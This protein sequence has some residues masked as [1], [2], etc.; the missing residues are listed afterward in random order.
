MRQRESSLGVAWGARRKPGL[1]SPANMS[2][3]G[4]SARHSVPN[5]TLSLVN[6]RL[7][8]GNVA[9][10]NRGRPGGYGARA[11]GSM[12]RERW[13]PAGRLALRGV[14]AA[15]SPGCGARSP[16]VMQ[17]RRMGG[18][19]RYPSYDRHTFAFSRRIAP[20]VCIFVC[21]LEIEGAG[22]TGCAPHPRSRVQFAHSKNAHEHTGSAETLR[23]SLRNGFTA[24][25]E[26]SPVNGFLATVVALSRNLTPAP[27]RQDHT[28]SPYAITTLV[29]RGFRVHRISP[30]VRDDGQRPHLP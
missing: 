8:K 29:S 25:S 21:P 5:Q 20:E 17:S 13:Y 16:R 24:Y 3:R 18:A 12:P 7:P 30:H 22:K 27:R 28:T 6:T 4:L 15:A 2:K 14:R 10:V 11:P 26:L 19:K 23:P 1:A 9:A